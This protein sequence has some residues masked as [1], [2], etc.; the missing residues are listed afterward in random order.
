[1]ASACLLCGLLLV[2]GA[3][4]PASSPADQDEDDG[5]EPQGGAA[6]SP[7]EIIPRV[8]LRQ[9]S[10]RQSSGV[11]VHDTTVETSIQF[12]RR[13]LLTYQMPYR[14]VDTPGG[15]LRGI[16]DVQVRSVGILASEPHL[17][18]ALLL[19]VV[20]DTASPP[21]TGGRT[22]RLLF[23]GGAAYKPR[24]SWIAY[25]VAQEQLSIGNG[26]GAKVNQL[27]LL[28]GSILFGWQ[29]NWMK[30]ELDTRVDF[31]ETSGALF[32]TA[33]V[34]SLMIGR[35]GSFVRVGTQLAGTREID[36]V[37]TGGVRYL[38]RLNR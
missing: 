35:V 7:I 9:S 22:K 13:L 33:E 30:L 4:A 27:D 15:Q 14:L 36:Y 5:G 28:V 10:A 38:F 37:L 11:M 3:Q 16:G 18:T 19:G 8:E 34:G 17:L 1:M 29:H 6:V 24:P 12:V 25:G 2:A 20:L 32:G 21:T 26:P 31:H 23:G